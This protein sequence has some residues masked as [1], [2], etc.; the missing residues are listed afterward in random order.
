MNSNNLPTEFHHQVAG[1]IKEKIQSWHDVSE[2]ELKV[3]KPCI[4][5]QL[6]AREVAFY[7]YINRSENNHYCQNPLR[8]TAKYYGVLNIADDET[9]SNIDNKSDT[10]NSLSYIVLEDKTSLFINPSIIDIKMGRQTFE[11]S[12][13]PVKKN[14][15][16]QKYYYQNEIGFRI[17]GFKVYQSDIHQY[18]SVDKIFGRSLAPQHVQA[19]LGVFFFD[20]NIIRIDAIKKIIEKLETFLVWMSSQHEYFFYC[21]SLLVIYDSLQSLN[22]KVRT[23]SRNTIAQDPSLTMIDFAHVVK[24]EEMIGHDE[25]YIYGLKKLLQTLHNIVD[26]F[27]KGSTAEQ[28]TFIESVIVLRDCFRR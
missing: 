16:L 25:G 10:S 15:I 18:I 9:K 27:C 20:G 28:A 19:G 5:P 23:H 13:D 17:T 4:K 1:H 7:E 2:Q 12:V 21:T 8:F 6:F 14:R 26:I 24:N 22:N 3:L 11:P